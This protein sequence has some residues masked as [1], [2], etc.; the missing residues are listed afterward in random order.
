MTVAG[1][2]SSD[3]VGAKGGATLTVTV[4]P[5]LP[6]EPEQVKVKLVVAASGPVTSLPAVTLVPFQPSDAM[7]VAA[8]T[9][10]QVNVDVPPLATLTGSAVRVTVGG[11]VGPLG[12]AS[13]CESPD[14]LQAQV[15]EAPTR[16]TMIVRIDER[17][18]VLTAPYTAIRETGQPVRRRS[19]RCGLGAHTVRG[20]TVDAYSMKSAGPRRPQDCSTSV[21]T[22]SAIARAAVRPGDSIPSRFTSPGIP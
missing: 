6:P 14:P 20:T 10:L 17:Y 1:S 3:T 19:R 22:W 13:D 12:F 15:S 2:A 8:S 9:E 16:A 11:P 5:S 21:S 7:Q 18:P 4:W